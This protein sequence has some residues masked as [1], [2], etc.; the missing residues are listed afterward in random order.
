MDW[1]ELSLPASRRV[2]A[3]RI[4]FRSEIRQRMREGS[5]AEAVAAVGRRHMVSHRPADPTMTADDYAA[6]ANEGQR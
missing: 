2:E 4:R 3:V 6:L 5:S 1:H